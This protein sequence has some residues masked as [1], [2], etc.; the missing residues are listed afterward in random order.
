MLLYNPFKRSLC[1][2]VLETYA[3]L[4]PA[5]IRTRIT[6]AVRWLPVGPSRLAL[7]RHYT[8]ASRGAVQLRRHY[9]RAIRP[10]ITLRRDAD[11]A[12]YRHYVRMVRTRITRAQYTCTPSETLNHAATPG[13]C[14]PIQPVPSLFVPLCV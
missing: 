12:P 1:S 8:R 4:A 6:R 10:R 14:A 2:F 3:P 7:Y 13:L 5:K 11:I 9:A